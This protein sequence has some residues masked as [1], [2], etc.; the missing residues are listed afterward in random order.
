VIDGLAFGVLDQL[1]VKAERE[2]LQLVALC[3]HPLA[4][5]T[6]LDARQSGNLCWSQSDAL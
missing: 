5:E 2:R 1:A 4:L 3:H 6:G